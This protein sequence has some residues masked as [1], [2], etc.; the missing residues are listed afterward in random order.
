MSSFL[1]NSRS[2]NT[3]KTYFSSF[4]RWSA[5][6]KEHGFNNLPAAPMHV[7]LYITN[8]IDKNCSPNVINSAIYSL[9]WVHELNGFADPTDN[10]FVKSLQESAKRLNGKPVNKKEPVSIDIIIELCTKFKDSNDLLIVRD[11]AMIVLSFSGFLRF[12]ELSSLKCKG[13]TV[14]DEFLK[15]FI[16][17]SKTDQY[18]QGNEILIA[19]G[20]TIACPVS[21]FQNYIDLAKLNL[22]SDFYIFRPIFRH[23]SIAKLIYKNKKISYTAAR[24][25][26]LKRLKLI[27]PTLNLGLHSL[28]AGGATAA[29]SS[30]VNER[31]IKRHGRWKSDSSKD[32]YIADTLEKRLS[33][34]QSLGL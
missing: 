34:S 30:E 5:F 23:K 25:N 18:R 26:I 22:N 19:K 3:N 12:D 6:I 10:S 28:R 15:L 17:H 27:A 31:C 16:S 20:K 14:Y 24:E 29:A 33:V 4:N 21:I 9:K 13:V 32:G 8:L 2:N 7:A 1:L 11:L